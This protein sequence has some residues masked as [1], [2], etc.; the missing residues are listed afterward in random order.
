ME[1]VVKND[2]LMLDMDEGEYLEPDARSI[3]LSIFYDKSIPLI[4]VDT[5]NIRQSLPTLS[6]SKIP[7][8]PCVT[9]IQQENSDIH[10]VNGIII[11]RD[12]EPTD[13]LTDQVII[14]E[15]WFPIDLNACLSINNWLDNKKI[16]LYTPL[17]FGQIIQLRSS[18]EEINL[19]EINEIDSDK[20]F[21]KGDRKINSVEGLNADLYPYQKS[22]VSFL[23]LVSDQSLGCILADEMGLGKTLQVIALFQLE[24]RA[25]KSI[26]LVIAPATLLENWRRECQFFAPELNIL[27]HTGPNRSGDYRSLLLHDIVILS[28]DTVIS[29]ELLLCEVD[30]NIV[31]LDEAQNIKNPLAKRTLAVKKL[32]RRVSIAVTG[33]P[34]ENSITDLWSISDFVLPS[35]LGTLEKFDSEFSNEH[36]DAS[37]LAPLVAPILLRRLVESVAK[38]LPKKIEIYQP[39]VMGDLLVNAYEQLRLETLEEYGAAAHMV[40]TTKLRVLCTHPILSGSW[41]VEASYE[42]A[43]YQRVLE[44]VSEIFANKEKALIFT[45]YQGMVDIFLNDMQVKWPNAYLNFIDGRV[46]V[47]ERQNII[48]IFSKHLGPGILFLN[49][50]AAGAGLNITA[51]NHVI[52]Y[53][54]EWNPALTAQASARAFRRKQVKP[55]TIHHLFF[56]DTLEE[57]IIERARFKRTLSDNAVTGH[58]GTIDSSVFEQALKV[59][60]FA[61]GDNIE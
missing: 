1:W 22:G 10:L 28:Y 56:V 53:N 15:K 57:V 34:L 35:I 30:W 60:P 42:M 2:K 47:K 37:D 40:A 51:A 55:V 61:K 44:L 11:N 43:K 29:D 9:F 33:T 12:F 26:S 46:K 4:T 41:G 18:K 54:P 17:T 14:K 23:K 50:K 52:H 19:V 20:I 48:D 8:E 59:T 31:V 32:P 24:K 16:P 21:L 6:F 27:I 25:K 3:F 38:D 13:R 58:D 45:S 7:A 36:T 39:I 5:P 49:P